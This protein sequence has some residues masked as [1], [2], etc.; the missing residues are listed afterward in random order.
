MTKFTDEQI[1][2]IFKHCDKSDC[3]DDCR[4]CAAHQDGEC[5]IPDLGAQVVQVINRKN[6]KIKNLK[7]KIAEHKAMLEAIDNEIFPLPFETD[8]DKSIR[9]AKSEAIKEFVERV[10][11]TSIGLEIGD[12]KK[13]KMTVV[14]TVAIDNLVKEMTEDKENV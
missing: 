9:T 13:F 3:I 8:F 14:S 1:I 10:K 4:D 11:E 6:A 7:A 5:A 2:N 12:D